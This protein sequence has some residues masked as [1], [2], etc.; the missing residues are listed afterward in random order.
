MHVYA[1]FFI[2]QLKGLFTDTINFR[3]NKKKRS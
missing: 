3:E 2:L 1:A